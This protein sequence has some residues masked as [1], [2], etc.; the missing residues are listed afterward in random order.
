MK[1]S[2]APKSSKPNGRRKPQARVLADLV[3]SVIDP[4]LAK[5]GFGEADLILNW[6]DIAG[7]RL[8]QF[9]EPIKLQWPPRG[10]NSFDAAPEPA[11]LIVRVESGFA[12]ECQHLSPII[13]ERINSHL[14]W[15]CVGRLAL[16]Q[17]PLQRSERQKRAA[18]PPTPQAQ[19]AAET[20]TRGIEDEPL[21]EALTRLGA[22]V[23][24]GR[25]R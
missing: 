24:N 14:G 21:R 20:A 5:Q 16:R 1:P 25:Q 11:T 7:E 18:S 13:I 3:G 15:R 23:L 9:C 10:R 4:V 22:R 2:S 8:A 17:G 19:S 6:D 12:L